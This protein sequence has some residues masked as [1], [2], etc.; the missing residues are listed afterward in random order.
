MGVSRAKNNKRISDTELKRRA[1]KARAEGGEGNGQEKDQEKGDSE[2]TVEDDAQ[3][4][5]NQ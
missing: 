2:E 4:T 5:S 3:G 1:R